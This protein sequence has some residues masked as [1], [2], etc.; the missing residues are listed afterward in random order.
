MDSLARC[1]ASIVLQIISICRFAFF[2]R[3][4]TDAKLVLDSRKRQNVVYLVRSLNSAT[5]SSK[6]YLTPVCLVDSSI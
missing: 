1:I 4:R 2:R 6:R 3:N 5:T